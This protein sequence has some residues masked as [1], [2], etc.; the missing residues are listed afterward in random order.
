MDNSNYI[1]NGYSYQI[2]KCYITTYSEKLAS[3][4]YDVRCLEARGTVKGF[5]ET[6]ESA[7]GGVYAL[8]DIYPS[9]N[10]NHA[11]SMIWKSLYFVIGKMREDRMCVEDALKFIYNFAES[12]QELVD[13]V[14]RLE[15]D[16]EEQEEAAD[17]EQ[18]ED[19]DFEDFDEDDEDFEDDDE[20]GDFEDDDDTPKFANVDE[21]IAYWRNELECDPDNVDTRRCLAV[22]LEEKASG[23][24][25]ESGE[26][27]IRVE[28]LKA[29]TLD[30]FKSLVNDYEQTDFYMWY[31][32]LMCSDDWG[33]YK[34]AR[35]EMFIEC[36]DYAVDQGCLTPDDKI[37]WLVMELACYEND[38]T[39]FISD[40]EQYYNLLSDAQEQ[41]DEEVS[42]AA[43]KI[44]DIIWHPE[45]I[46]E[47]D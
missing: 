39:D 16:N 43:G 42:E 29:E 28:K 15:R 4:L 27:D 31:A 8:L 37:G 36:V 10:D 3:I 22:A 23:I 6:A 26:S 9:L 1:S 20:E 47:E 7:Y 21:E 11:Y 13:V 30:F 33:S 34:L 18:D 41:G 24:M 32:L 2:G 14:E 25:E 12:Y 5:L 46:K 38:P 35:P 19:D 45:N 40:K 44:I 17:D